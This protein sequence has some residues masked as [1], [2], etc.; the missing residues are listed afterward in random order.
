MLV[1]PQL[2]QQHQMMQHQAAQQRRQAIM[3][4]QYSGI[5]VAMPNGMNPMA[6]QMNAQ[7]AM[8]GATPMAR[9][10]NLPQH[11]AAQQQQAQ[12][13]MEQQQAQQQAQ[14]RNFF[15]SFHNH[16]YINQIRSNNISSRCSR[17]IWLSNSTKMPKTTRRIINRDNPGN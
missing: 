5:P 10:I 7:F 11:L 8:R 15:L 14:V 9:P 13:S 3:A 17:S 4:Q 2:M 12:H 1:N 16:H 6:A